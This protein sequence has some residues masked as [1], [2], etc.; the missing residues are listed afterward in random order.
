METLF[1]DIVRALG[2]SILNS[3]WQSGILYAVLF[4]ILLLTPKL[5]SSY[6]HN[7][8][9][10]TLLAMFAWFV[11]TFAQHLSLSNGVSKSGVS[12]NVYELNTLVQNIPQTFADKAESY[13]PII[14]S[15]YILGLIV[16]LVLV[17]RGFIYLNKLKT[18]ALSEVSSQW[19]NLFEHCKRELN[20]SKDIQFKL[21]KLVDVPVVVGY[22][23]PIILF[24]VTLVTT[25]DEDQVEAILIHELTHI[26]RNDYLLNIIKTCIETILFF[27][28]FI[29][30]T[31]RFIQIEREHACDDLVV[32]VSGKPLSYAKTL[33]KLEIIQQEKLPSYALA[34]TGKTQHL[35]QR[36]KRIT[37]MKANYLN[38][39]QQLA[40]LTLALA[41]LL[42]IAWTNPE[43]KEK[44]TEITDNIK[45]IEIFNLTKMAS[46][47]AKVDT[48]KKKSPVKITITDENGKTTTYS[49]LSPEKDS[50]I[51]FKAKSAMSLKPTR[52][53]IISG[54]V[55]ISDSTYRMMPISAKAFKMDPDSITAVKII[56]MLPGIEITT[57]DG[58]TEIFKLGKTSEGST[59]DLTK[60][61]EVVGSALAGRTGQA[62]NI[63]FSRTSPG[64]NK[65]V[66]LR[67][68][69]LNAAKGP[70]IV[71]DGDTVS[72]QLFS[73]IHVDRIADISV[74]RDASTSP[75]GVINIRLIEP[76]AK[77]LEM[78]TQDK[79]ERE[80]RSTKEYQN[81]KKDFDKK[82][83]ALKK[84][85]QKKSSGN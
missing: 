31:S 23:K 19:T 36:I 7:L 4:V 33:L 30:L 22:F 28:P 15:M 40:A 58:K 54:K 57:K 21:S 85:Q 51:F 74:L 68:G 27:N 49:D 50:I 64:S 56:K 82:L 9:F 39:K 79:A 73:S 47:D 75:N 45:S 80:L 6:R 81:I 67:G 5:K 18:T 41:G 8:S 48:I 59:S 61:L 10:A 43:I 37:N 29:W 25:L 26:K 44:T 14:F 60:E 34:T 17:S 55:L 66:V 53:M 38:L 20:I 1:Q 2:W 78:R 84:K 12:L 71:I 46:A 35:Y 72:S 77:I 62:E 76:A 24:P 70:A 3:I 65:T 69:P 11:F 32:D 52:Q 63:R 83:E 13:F 42:S 16:Q